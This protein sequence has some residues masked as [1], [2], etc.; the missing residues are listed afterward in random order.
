MADNQRGSR[1]TEVAAQRRRRGDE[2]LAAA[3]RL[4]IPPEV[5][6]RLKAEGLRPRWVND[7]GNRMHN[8]T[9]RDDYDKVQGVDPVPVG[10]AENG[11]PIMAHLL[12]KPIDFINEDHAKA[13]RRR[14][15][16]ETAL[17]RGE[18]PNAGGANQRPAES[19]TYVVE[20]TTIGRGNQV[21]D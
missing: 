10:T 6:E 9:A 21:L 18:V 13:E 4:P 8:L 5:A 20:G 1:A 14:K 19:P 12:A 17:V 11:E 15:E 2:T 7:H 16:Q 3:K